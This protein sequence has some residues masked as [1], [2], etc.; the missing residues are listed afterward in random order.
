MISQFHMPCTTR[1]SRLP[2]IIAL[3]MCVLR[4]ASVESALLWLSSLEKFH[5]CQEATFCFPLIG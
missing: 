5:A 2:K 3:I 4:S 1:E